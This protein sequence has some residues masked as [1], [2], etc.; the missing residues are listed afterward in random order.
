MRLRDEELI[1]AVQAD[2][3]ELLVPKSAV[4]AAERLLSIAFRFL[5]CRAALVRH[6]TLVVAARGDAAEFVM[7]RA[8]DEGPVLKGETLVLRIG[9]RAALELC[10]PADGLPFES[11]DRAAL[12]LLGEGYAKVLDTLGVVTDAAEI[13]R[14]ALDK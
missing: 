3:A 2:A 14:H 7:T 11:I 4:A 9:G 8:S 5:P 6:G 12:R 10:D 13:A 1:A